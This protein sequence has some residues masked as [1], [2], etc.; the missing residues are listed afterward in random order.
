MAVIFSAWTVANIPNLNAR[1]LTTG[2]LLS[3]SNSTGL[4]TSNIFLSREAPKYL[5]A[6]IVNTT[7]S[8]VGVAFILAY[9]MYLR[10][11]NRALDAN[12]RPGGLFGEDKLDRGEGF[13][14]Q[15]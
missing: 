9:S 13:R 7:F 12:D 11:L 5:T 10:L 8:A 6:L 3:I 15:P 14:F 4:I 1:A 2:I